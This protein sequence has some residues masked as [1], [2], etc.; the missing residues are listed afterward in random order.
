MLCGVVSHS[1]THLLRNAMRRNKKAYVGA[2]VTTTA[3][4]VVDGYCCTFFCSTP[5][6]AVIVKLYAVAKLVMLLSFTLNDCIL[7]VC[8]KLC[9]FFHSHSL[10]LFS[11]PYVCK[12]NGL[13]GKKII[14]IFFKGKKP[15]TP[16]FCLCIFALFKTNNGS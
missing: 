5:S 7:V 10:S 8:H 12:F 16:P 15:C 9:R 13:F 11:Q 6:S 14:F 3:A 4:T 1:R 2:L